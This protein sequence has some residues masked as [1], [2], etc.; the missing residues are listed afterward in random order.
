[1]TK[2]ILFSLISSLLSF[3]SVGQDTIPHIKGNV[4]ISVKKGTIE[5]DLTVSNMP[6]IQDYFLRLNSGMNIRYI[7]NAEPNM[8]SL[9][10]GRSSHDT[11]SYGESSAYYIPGGKAFGKY[12]PNS[13]RLN[14]VGMYPVITDTTSVVD[15]RGNI[16]FNGTSLRADGIQSAWSPILYDV[17]KDKSYEKVTYDLDI[18][19]NDCKVI[20]INGN[21]PVQGTRA[22]VSSNQ[23]QDLTMF[24]GDYKSVSIHDSHFLNPDA[25]EQELAQLEQM[26]STYKKYL[27]EH[28]GIPY[29]GK[30]VYIQTTPVSK[31]NSWLFASFPTI[32][33]VGWG[34]GLKSFVSKTEGRSLMRYMAHELSHY[35]FGSYRRFNSELG[36]MI[37]EG[38]A[39][40]L[41]W[42]I[43]RKL[44]SDSLYYE[45]MAQK[46]AAIRNF[47]PIPVADVRS[48]NDYY[49]R[50][51]YVY[52]YAPILFS[53]IEREIG[54]K[55]MWEWIKSL[56]K[57]N[58][59]FTNY[60]FFEET[61]GEVL[62]DD[63][64][65]NS[66]REKYFASKNS[67][68][69]ALSTLGIG[70]DEIIQNVSEPTTKTYYYFFFTRPRADAGSSQNR[71]IKHTRIAEITCMPNELSIMA[72]P[73]F[74]KLG[75]ECENDSGCY[76]DFNTYASR[77]MAESALQR[78]LNV[79][80][81]EGKLTVKVLEP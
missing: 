68:Q 49:D 8:K 53:A 77:E 35:Y 56:L 81:K 52:Y 55:N 26:L 59:V 48:A 76:S 18:T 64:K 19:C 12:L 7:R 80:N 50:E 6:R 78:W 39:E 37:S 21:E 70:S 66:L 25:N 46:A 63:K 73:I 29:N 61:L 2:P 33:K 4:I 75:D 17:Q 22:R 20:Y 43:T 15:W 74:K 54:V 23:A 24:V 40:Y 44:I 13:I 11:L 3:S 47:K 60:K 38:F 31:N 79:H 42:Q 36:D 34:E 57:T 16:A 32:V 27:V 71:V 41:A 62:K 5:C 72:E 30:T 14:Y 65:L 9:R 51:R 69:N 28:L 67:L 58:T 1:M 10:Y 45:T